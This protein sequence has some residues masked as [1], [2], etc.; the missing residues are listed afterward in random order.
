MVLL[1][2]P[3]HRWAVLNSSIAEVDPKMGSAH[4]MRLGGTSVIVEDTRISGHVQLSSLRVVLPDT[5]HLYILPLS[6]VGDPVDGVEAISSA[7]LWYVVSGRQ[8]LIDVKVFSGRS[9]AREIFI[10]EVI[11]RRCLSF[12]NRLIYPILC[13]LYLFGWHGT[14]HPHPSYLS[15]HLWPMLASLSGFL[16]GG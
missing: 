9:E 16:C 7:T 15:P 3:F 10:T 13:N 5:M 1:P 6:E 12:A 11:Y 4:A 8:Y 2:S 14:P